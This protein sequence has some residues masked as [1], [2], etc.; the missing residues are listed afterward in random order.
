MRFEKKERKLCSWRFD[1]ELG[2]ACGQSRER[3]KA[4]LLEMRCG[5]ACRL[6]PV[7]LFDVEKL[8]GMASVIGGN[9]ARTPCKVVQKPKHKKMTGTTFVMTVSG[10]RYPQNTGYVPNATKRNMFFTGVKRLTLVPVCV[11]FDVL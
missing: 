5:A 9:I 3:K 2:V 7:E 11:F 10:R 6:R 8:A 4:L 1:A